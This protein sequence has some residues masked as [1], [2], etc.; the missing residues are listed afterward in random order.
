MA[1]VLLSDALW[2]LEVAADGGRLRAVLTSESLMCRVGDIIARAAIRHRHSVHPLICG[3][4][5][6][7]RA[8]RTDEPVI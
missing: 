4:G 7:E 3:N 2:D 1:A 6:D 8:N 5:A